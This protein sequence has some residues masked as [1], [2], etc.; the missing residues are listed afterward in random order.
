MRDW[1]TLH[2]VIYR[3][4]LGAVVLA[5]VIPVW[6]SGHRPMWPVALITVSVVTAVGVVLARE[7]HLR[8]WLSRR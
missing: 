6:T 1:F 8:D 2:S 4:V 3:L 7:P 5:V